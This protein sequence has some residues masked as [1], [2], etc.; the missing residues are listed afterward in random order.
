LLLRF[1]ARTLGG[2]VPADALLVLLRVGVV[3]LV[4]EDV[5]FGPVVGVEVMLEDRALK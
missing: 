4:L 3:R 2:L 5:E 1:L